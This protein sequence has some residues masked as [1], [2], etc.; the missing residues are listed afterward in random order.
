MN[1]G[2]RHIIES[3]VLILIKSEKKL[4]GY[5]DDGL[6]QVK[7]VN[8]E[9]KIFSRVEAEANKMWIISRMWE[10][11]FPDK[12]T[13]KILLYNRELQLLKYSNYQCKENIEVTLST[14]FL[15]ESN[16][17]ELPDIFWGIKVSSWST[18]RT[19]RRAGRTRPIR[20]VSFDDIWTLDLKIE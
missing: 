7:E 3:Y 6:Q 10:Q 16:F 20:T 13:S 1:S 14:C 5:Q 9:L 12:K 4:I 15:W 11:H 2:K 18:V 8:A 19:P 17:Q